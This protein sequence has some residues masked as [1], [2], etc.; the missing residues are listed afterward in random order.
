M[1]VY[2]LDFKPI[3]LFDIP[4]FGISHFDSNF[5][6]LIHP[7]IGRDESVSALPD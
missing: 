4:L 3:L 6:L 1:F 5:Y 7:C 2:Y